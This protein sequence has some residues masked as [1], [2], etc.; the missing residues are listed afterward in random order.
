M[1]FLGDVDQLE[2][3]R[4]RSYQL[5]RD[6]GVPDAQIALVEAYAKEQ[7]L[8][9]TPGTPD[10]VYSDLLT[11]DLA[12]VTPSMAGPR[13][14]QDRVALGKVKENFAVELP[15][16]LA[17]AKPR[18]GLPMQ[19][20][21]PVEPAPNGAACMSDSECV[22][23]FCFNDVCQPQTGAPAVSNNNVIFLAF[24]LLAG[25]LWMVRRRLPGRH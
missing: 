2:V 16:L 9:F 10:A 24:A 13:R 18:A 21:A 3:R 25:G 5:A 11:L 15:K 14:P 23:K 22:S 19:P 6:S 8:F 12:S 4:K 17:A 1:H 20:V 7:G